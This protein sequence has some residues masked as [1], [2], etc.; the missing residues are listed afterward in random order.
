MSQNSRSPRRSFGPRPIADLGLAALGKLVQKRGF[1]AADLV[2][3]WPEIVGEEWGALTRPHRLSAPQHGRH[4]SGATLVLR[5][6]PHAALFA[7]HAEPELLESVNAYLGPGAIASIRLEQGPLARTRAPVPPAQPA[8]EPA[9]VV[10][11]EGGLDEIDDPALRAALL[12]LGISVY[13]AD[14]SA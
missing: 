5:V 11:L 9:L 13:G 8:P 4:Q 3:Y 7:Q 12:D 14:T 6:E 2:V 1:A 10:A